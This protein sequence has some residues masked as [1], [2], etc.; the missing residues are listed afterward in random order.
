MLNFYL[1]SSSVKRTGGDLGHYAISFD[2][3]MG[4]AA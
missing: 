2:E 4:K 1:P 3:L